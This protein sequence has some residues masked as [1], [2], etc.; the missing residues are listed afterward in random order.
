[1]H[2]FATTPRLNSIIE[3]SPDCQPLKSHMARS[4]FVRR[5]AY[6]LVNNDIRVGMCAFAMRGGV[7]ERE[8][9][10]EH[11]PNQPIIY[12]RHVHITIIILLFSNTPEKP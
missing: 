12:H 1:M 3:L 11:E 4:L 9:V 10:H 2:S 8:V 5:F 7:D 6:T